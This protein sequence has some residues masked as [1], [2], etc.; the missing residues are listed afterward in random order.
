MD[1]GRQL[2]KGI[3]WMKLTFATCYVGGH[4]YNDKVETKIRLLKASL[5]RTI[6]DERLSVSQWEV[7]SSVTANTILGL[8]NIVGYYENMNLI[9]SNRLCLKRNNDRTRTAPVEVTGN[10]N[11]LLEE[12]KIIFNS[13]FE[14]W[15]VSIYQS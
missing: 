5:E 9:T 13:W 6:Q 11:K 12:N 15:L 1:K 4:N 2:V 10:L 8:D 3:E 7:L 14:A